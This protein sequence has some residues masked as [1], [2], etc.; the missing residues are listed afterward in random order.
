MMLYQYSNP[1]ALYQCFLVE[2]QPWG[3]KFFTKYRL[4]YI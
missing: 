3:L 1:S 4:N 2:N